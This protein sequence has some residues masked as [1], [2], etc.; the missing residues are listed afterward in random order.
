[1]KALR[2]TDYGHLS[3][4]SV[5]RPA[6][7]ENEVL[8]KV[9]TA[10][11]NPVDWK[12]AN[13]D[14]S[15]LVNQ[16]LPLTL[17]WDLAGDIVELGEGV[18]TFNAGERVFAM[19]VIGYDGA[20]AEY[21]IVNV[22]G[23]AKAPQSVDLVEAAAY[24]LVSLT[25]WQA[26]FVAGQ[27][28]AGQ[29]VLIHAGAGGVGH[30]AIQ[31]AKAK[32]AK[33]I[34]TTSAVN[35]DFVAHLGA[36]EII[37]YREED[38]E[39]VLANAKVDLVFDTLGGD[40]QLKSL[41]VLKRGGKLVSITGV[42]GETEAKAKTLGVSAEFVF[43]QANGEQLR[44]IAEMVDAGELAVTVAQTFSLDDV[45]TAFDISAQGRVRGKLVMK[46]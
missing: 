16:S 21:C 34:T 22:N 6:P 5:S 42:T 26:M 32:G 10:G 2:I 14:L 25:S 29:R 4:E 23:L 7:S 40:T 46:I 17:G 1:M 27:L 33:V 24:P 8:V 18:T 30:I 12:I 43:V 28:E 35:R 15:V 31:L 45:T 36:D 13:G 19:P 3:I 37:D 9:A 44:H 39:T 20:F 11:I 41:N 38:F